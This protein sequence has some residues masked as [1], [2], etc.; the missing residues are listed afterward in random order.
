MPD[1][2]YTRVLYIVNNLFN[3]ILYG[4]FL[5]KKIS[6]IIILNQKKKKKR[7][8]KANNQLQVIKKRCNIEQKFFSFYFLNEILIDLLNFKK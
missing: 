5:L 4:I 1:S 3:I 6:I 8:N 7:K 2:K